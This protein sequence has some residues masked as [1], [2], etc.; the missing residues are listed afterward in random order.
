MRTLEGGIQYFWCKTCQRKFAD[1]DALPGM[2]TPIPQVSSSLNMY[3]SG[4]SIDEIRLHLDQEH[5][6]KP[7][8]STIYDWIKRFSTEAKG[9]TD[10]Y[11]PNVGDVWLADETVI[12]LNGV[13]AFFWDCIDV[14]TRFLLA[15]QLTYNRTSQH[16]KNLIEMAVKRAGKQPKKLITDKLGAYVEGAESALGGDTEHIQTKGFIVQPNTNLLERFHGSLKSRTKVMRGLK[17]PEGA[18]M[19]LDGWLVYYNFFRPHESLENKTPAEKAGIKSTMQNWRDVVVQSRGTNL[20]Y[21]TGEL[22]ARLPEW[23]RLTRPSVDMGTP[24]RYGL[25]KKKKG[26]MKKRV[27]RAPVI[28]VARM[29]M[30]TAISLNRRKSR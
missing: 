7:S 14:K 26:V 16:A 23:Q 10:T 6:N 24:T 11:K 28:E 25:T 19:I 8:D 5:N 13:K 27:K 1:N 17:T 3:Y 18:S 2:H 30:I 15:S 4:M 22:L 21:D 20:N 9:A 29:P 12:D